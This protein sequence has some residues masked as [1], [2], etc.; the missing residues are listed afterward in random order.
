MQDTPI[1]Q[2]P[3]D[4]SELSLLEIIYFLKGAYKTIL[5]SGAIGIAL[6]ITYVVITPK[7]YEARAQIGA[8]NNI[9]PVGIN[10]EEPA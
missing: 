9:S 3:Q 1:T 4:N 7:Q 10:I 2:P 5:I 8:A 6:S